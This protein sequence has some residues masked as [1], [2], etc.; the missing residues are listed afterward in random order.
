MAETNTPK[1]TPSYVIKAQ[2]NYRKKFDVVSIRLPKGFADVIRE[3]TGESVNGYITRLVK[4]DM[5]KRFDID[6]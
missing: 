4:E 6:I 3:K 2:N 5:K 1:K